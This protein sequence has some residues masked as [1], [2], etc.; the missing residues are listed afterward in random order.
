MFAFFSLMTLA[1]M[2]PFLKVDLDLPSQ[3]DAPTLVTVAM[4]DTSPG[5]GDQSLVDMVQ[6]KDLSKVGSHLIVQSSALFKDMGYLVS[7][8]KDRAQKIDFVKGEV[9]D[10]LKSASAVLGGVWV[11]AD[12]AGTR[13]DNQTFLMES[14]RKQ[15]VSKLDTEVPNEFFLFIAAD[16][17]ERTDWLIMKSPVMVIDWVMLSDNEKI[18]LRARGIGRGKTTPLFLDKGEANLK[19]AI[20]SA[21]ESLKAEE[22]QGL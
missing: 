7:L 21:I 1:C 11:S 5:E 6:G 12:T 19:M 18:T 10:A 4:I 20:D 17:Y 3:N 14:Y 15:L 13:I 22:K 8:D 9:V 2:K 16:V